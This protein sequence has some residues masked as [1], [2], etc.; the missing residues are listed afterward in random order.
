VV[1]H[2]ELYLALP[3]FE[4]QTELLPESGKHRIREA[5]GCVKTFDPSRPAP[6]LSGA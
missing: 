2:N 4:I 3:G 1:N 5:V 6:S